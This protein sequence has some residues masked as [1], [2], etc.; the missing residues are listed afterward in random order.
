V[1]RVRG[2]GRERGGE[3]GGEG[4]AERERLRG[5]GRMKNTKEK[6]AAGQHKW[7]HAKP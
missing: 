6:D 4:R 1:V 3:R 5:G 7:L 2:R